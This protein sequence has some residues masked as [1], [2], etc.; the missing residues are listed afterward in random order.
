MKKVGKIVLGGLYQ[1]IY[2]LALYSII[3]VIAAY[4]AVLIYQASHLG[5]LFTET[6]A[7]QKESIAEI[8]RQT[9]DSVLSS[10]MTSST[11][12]QAYIANDL[13]IEL[14]GVGRLPVDETE[15]QKIHSERVLLS[16]HGFFLFFFHYNKFFAA[17]GQ[18]E[19][20]RRK[21]FDKKR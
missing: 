3:L 16:R 5:A 10:S 2:N 14:I 7:K 18:A 9:M 19:L 21:Y 4:T 17:N 20:C 6:N 11:Q 13:F 12:M 15:Q 8:S 1:K